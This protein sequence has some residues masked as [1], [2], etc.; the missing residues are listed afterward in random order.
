MATTAQYAVTTSWTKRIV[1][2]TTDWT[3]Q[4][5]GP[6]PFYARYDA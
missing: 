3:F 4:N 6:E 1:T 5:I 2:A